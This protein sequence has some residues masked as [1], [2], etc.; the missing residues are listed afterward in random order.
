MFCSPPRRR[1]ADR[2][3]SVSAI[4]RP[5]SSKRS[6]RPFGRRRSVRRTAAAADVPERQGPRRAAV[7][8]RPGAL[9]TVPV[10]RRDAAR[11]AAVLGTR[12]RRPCGHPGARYAR[13]RRGA[14]CETSL[15]FQDAGLKRPHPASFSTAT[16]VVSSAWSRWDSTA[17]RRRVFLAVEVGAFGELRAVVE[18]GR[19]TPCFTR[20]RTGLRSAAPTS[21]RSSAVL[22]PVRY[23]PRS[24]WL[25]PA[26]TPSSGVLLA[27]RDRRPRSSRAR[28]NHVA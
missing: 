5:C 25:P 18:P 4:S 28:R 19:H 23:S 1:A 6:S 8:N 15:R 7:L 26:V 13:P 21:P 11:R 10:P 14:R 9:L 17:S 12:P 16:Y 3:A 24:P 2:A 20:R 27:V 22:A